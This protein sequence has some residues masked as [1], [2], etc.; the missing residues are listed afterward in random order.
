M[1]LYIAIKL[2]KFLKSKK[3]KLKGQRRKPDKLNRMIVVK[4][5]LKE[6]TLAFTY[7]K[8]FVPIYF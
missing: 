7:L 4:F 5:S 8:K 6:M 3:T 2:T 1:Y